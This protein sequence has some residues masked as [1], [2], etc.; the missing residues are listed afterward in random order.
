MLNQHNVALHFSR[1]QKWKF[2]LC[3]LWGKHVIKHRRSEEFVLAVVVAGNLLDLT[4]AF[5][6][7]NSCWEFFL[8]L[9]PFKDDDVT[10]H[11][12]GFSKRAL[13]IQGGVLWTFLVLRAWICSKHT[14]VEKTEIKLSLITPGFMAHAH[15]AGWSDAFISLGSWGLEISNAMSRPD[16]FFHHLLPCGFFILLPCLSSSLFSILS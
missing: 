7:L 1:L 16:L 3:S 6:F 8:E 9:C 4:L 11:Y 15:S 14:L 13:L 10:S 2:T 12:Y 5:I